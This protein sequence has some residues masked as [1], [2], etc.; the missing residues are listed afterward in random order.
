MKH[1]YN[2]LPSRGYNTQEPAITSQ[3]ERKKKK[4]PR[5]PRCFDLSGENNWQGDA[6]ERLVSITILASHHQTGTAQQRK[7]K[8][9]TQKNKMH[10]IRKH[11]TNQDPN[12]N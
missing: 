3:K 9:S 8:H 7:H 10:A 6:T 2:P 1:V 4:N 11:L 5:L 12:R